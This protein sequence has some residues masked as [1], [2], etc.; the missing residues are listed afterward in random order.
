MRKQTQETENKAQMLVKRAP[1]ARIMQNIQQVPMRKNSDRG[2]NRFSQQFSDRRFNS[3]YATP[4]AVGGDVF[5]FKK[6]HMSNKGNFDKI[7]KSAANAEMQVLNPDLHREVE[8][9][10]LIAAVE[11]GNQQTGQGIINNFTLTQATYK[12]RR[13]SGRYGR[14]KENIHLNLGVEHR[15]GHININQKYNSFNPTT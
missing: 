5:A 4:N 3:E 1:P 13:Q 15:Q 11:V 12:Q 8:R 14:G 9:Q 10:R 7:R 6:S 2:S